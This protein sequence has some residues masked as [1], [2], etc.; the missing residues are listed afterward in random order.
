MSQEAADAL[1]NEYLR[2]TGQLPASGGGSGSG[3]GRSGGSGSESSGSA[4]GSAGA[5]AARGAATGLAASLAA[6]MPAISP[7]AVAA[8]LR[9][10]GAKQNEVLQY[11]NEEIKDKNE[12]AGGLK[13]RGWNDSV[14]NS[15]GRSNQRN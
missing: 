9:E 6:Q 8:Q 5:A 12:V 7:W 4:A 15:K 1:R 13:K 11:L 10:A 2:Q 14:S 3:G